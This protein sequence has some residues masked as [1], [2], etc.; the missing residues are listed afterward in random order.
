VVVL[1]VLESGAVA[2]VVLELG[3]VMLVALHLSCL[4]M[5]RLTVALVTHPVTSTM[6]QNNTILF[7]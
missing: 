7:S 5:A 3:V 4:I 6:I 1:V 2:L